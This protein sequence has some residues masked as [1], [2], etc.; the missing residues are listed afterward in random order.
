MERPRRLLGR[1]KPG[2][3]LRRRLSQVHKANLGLGH[4]RQARPH[5]RVA[6]QVAQGTV[7]DSVVGN[8][9]Q[10][11]FHGLARFA[12]SRAGGGFEQDRVNRRKP[13]DRA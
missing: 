8:A 12:L 3:R 1:R 13:A 11:L 4:R 5:L 9:P 10:L 2:F 7:T 6:R